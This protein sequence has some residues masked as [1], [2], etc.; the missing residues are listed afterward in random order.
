MP[1]DVT[2]PARRLYAAINAHDPAAILASLTDDF[3]GEVSAGMPLGVG[4]RH[5]GPRTMLERVWGRVFSAYD[6]R[7]EPE[8]YLVVTDGSLVILGSYVGV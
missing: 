2:D 1:A 6:L 4:G 3:V 7:V 8:T 5:E